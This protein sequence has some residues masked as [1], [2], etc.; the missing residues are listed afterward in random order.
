[1]HLDVVH[2]DVVHGSFQRGIYKE[3]NSF[4]NN[5][6]DCIMKNGSTSARKK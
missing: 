6:I 2:L 1:M 3:N 4:A 5:W